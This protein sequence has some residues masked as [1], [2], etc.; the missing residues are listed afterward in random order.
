MRDF[1]PLIYLEMATQTMAVR[2]IFLIVFLLMLVAR[3]MVLGDDANVFNPFLKAVDH[4]IRDNRGQGDVIYLRGVNLGGWL[5]FEGWQ[6]PMDAGSLKDDWSVRE[7][8]ANRF[9]PEMRH[10]AKWHRPQ[11]STDAKNR[12]R[13]ALRRFLC[14]SISAADLLLRISILRAEP[15]R[16]T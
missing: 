14:P 7:K 2:F 6:T 3:G 5:L 12:Q 13:S 4:E 16:H 9:G 10:C 8:L 15:N 1:F 11:A